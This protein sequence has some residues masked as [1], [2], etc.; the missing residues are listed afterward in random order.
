LGIVARPA[1][2]G[3]TS[4]GAGANCPSARSPSDN[5]MITSSAH[6]GWRQESTWWSSYEALNSYRLGTQPL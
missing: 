1:S 6:R 5:I 4:A 2:I 3:K